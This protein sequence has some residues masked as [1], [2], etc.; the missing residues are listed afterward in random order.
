MSDQKVNNIVIKLDEVYVITKRFA[1][2]VYFLRNKAYSKG[3]LCDTKKAANAVVFTSKEEAND[4][5]N[6]LNKYRKK[7]KHGVEKA[8]TF[9]ATNIRFNKLSRYRWTNSSLTITNE[10]RSVDQLSKNYKLN[11]KEE[12]LEILKEH[13]EDSNK[14]LKD[15]KQAL[16]GLDDW[17]KREL[18]RIEESYKE[19]LQTHKQNIKNEQNYIKDLQAI[20]YDDIV[21]NS[22]TKQDQKYKIL[23]GGLE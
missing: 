20:N 18:E 14:N 2:N 10:Y 23:Y 12:N 19:K 9:F 1:G 21:D 4:I 7:V 3:Y 11:N 22:L 8:S 5:C 16:T 6:E 15:Y 17:K 13:I